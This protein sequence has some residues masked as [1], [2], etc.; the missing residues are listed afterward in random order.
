MKVRLLRAAAHL[1][2]QR[3]AKQVR[4]PIFKRAQ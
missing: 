2:L 4:K 1:A 3:H